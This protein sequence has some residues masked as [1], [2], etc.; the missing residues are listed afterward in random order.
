MHFVPD[1]SVVPALPAWAA[2]PP[3]NEVPAP[4]AVHAVLARTEDVAV[5]LVGGHVYSTGVELDLA[6]RRRRDD[7]AALDLFSLVEGHGH[8]HRAN[9]APGRLLLGVELADGSVAT[10]AGPEPDRDDAPR[11]GDRGGRG[12]GRSVDKKLWL[13]PVPPDGDV[14]VVCACE[15]LGVPETR[16]VIPAAVLAGA[17]DRV[18]TLWPS[19]PRVEHT[20]PPHVPL[21][22]PAGGWFERVLGPQ[23]RPGDPG[24]RG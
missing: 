10:N 22:L 20:E 14:V 5:A 6:V 19:E 7:P 9:A 16:T 18:V 13:T 3:E 4:V 12:G 11:L 17:R 1:D 21:S 24:S 15:A 2:G 8:R 23:E